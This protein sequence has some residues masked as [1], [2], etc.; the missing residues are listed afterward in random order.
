MAAELRPYVRA[1][2]PGGGEQYLDQLLDLANGE[3]ILALVE[4]AE[5]KLNDEH[6]DRQYLLETLINDVRHVLR[7]EPERRAKVILFKA[8]GR[9]YAQEEWRIPE[10]AIDPE[11]MSRSPDFHQLIGGTVLVPEQEPWGYPHLIV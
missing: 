8:S 9:N 5:T 4:L 11:D 6:A 10:G 3:R 7:P 1:H 2:V